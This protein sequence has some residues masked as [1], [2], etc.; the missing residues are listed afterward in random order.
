MLV[1]KAKSDITLLR[2]NKANDNSTKK[3]SPVTDNLNLTITDLVKKLD[4]QYNIQE[5]NFLARYISKYIKYKVEKIH[6]E[7]KF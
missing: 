5:K 7:V 2:I 3:D 4:K 1:N 6:L